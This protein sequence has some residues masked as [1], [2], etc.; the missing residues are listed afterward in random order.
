MSSVYKIFTHAENQY[1]FKFKK[2]DSNGDIPAPTMRVRERCN[3]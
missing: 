1:K 2:I 3:K